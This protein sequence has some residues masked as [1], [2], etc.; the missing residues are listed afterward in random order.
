MTRMSDCRM[1]DR[2]S[3]LKG[4]EVTLPCSYRRICFI[5]GAQVSSVTG[6]HI[7]YPARNV[8]HRYIQPPEPAIRMAYI[9]RVAGHPPDIRR[10][11]AIKIASSGGRAF[12]GT[13][14]FN[15]CFVGI[16]C[17]YSCVLLEQ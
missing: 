9:R 14:C 12:F 8:I 3:F 1:M 17:F 13:G 2:H 5:S 7:S 11:T 4:R 6:Q 16:G 10:I 15:V